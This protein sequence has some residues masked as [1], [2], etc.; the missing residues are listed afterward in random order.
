MYV[1]HFAYCLEQGTYFCNICLEQ[2]CKFI[3][4]PLEQV[5]SLRDSAAYTRS[6]FYGVPPPGAI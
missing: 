2:G 5:Q 4:L 6:K 3:F 1:L